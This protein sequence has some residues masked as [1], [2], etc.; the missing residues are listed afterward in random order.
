VA[1]AEKENTKKA[2]LLGY[3]EMKQIDPSVLASGK[4]GALTSCPS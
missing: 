3:E 4:F 1:K 2:E